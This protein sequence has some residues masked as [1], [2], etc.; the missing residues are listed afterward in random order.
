M[1]LRIREDIVIKRYFELGR[2]DA[3]D[4]KVGDIAK[5]LHISKNTILKVL[6]TY[7]K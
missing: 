5:K 1:I 6:E 2:S 3:T 7:R 4:W